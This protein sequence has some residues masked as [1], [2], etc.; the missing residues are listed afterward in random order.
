MVASTSFRRMTLFPDYDE[1]LWAARQG[2]RGNAGRGTVHPPKLSSHK[3]HLEP[4]SKGKPKDNFSNSSKQSSTKGSNASDSEGPPPLPSARRK[5]TRKAKKGRKGKKGEKGRKEGKGK[6]RK[7]QRQRNKP[8]RGYPSSSSGSL[9]SDSDSSS[10][11]SSCNQRTT[12]NRRNG[13]GKT[14]PGQGRRTTAEFWG[15]DPSTG[16]KKRIYGMAVNGTKIDAAAAPPDMRSRD[17]T[18]LFNAAVD[19]LSLPGMFGNSFN[20]DDMYNKAQRTTEMATFYGDRQEGLNSQLPLEDTQTTRIRPDQKLAKSV[21]ICEGCWKSRGPV[22]RTTRKRSPAFHV[23]PSLQ[24][25]H[26]RQ[27]HH[28]RLPPP[29]HLCDLPVLLQS[30]IQ[31]PTACL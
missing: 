20:G 19:V 2:C 15:P 13:K 29:P 10:S 24:C 5:S 30:P 22:F 12:Q 9:S 8:R 11:K 23:F 18:E 27:V 6:P 3:R 31:H 28:T 7:R 25:V 26:H 21:Q 1:A 16:D 4:H 17:S 14:S